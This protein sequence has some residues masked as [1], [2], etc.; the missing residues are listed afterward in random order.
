M[1]T[2]NNNANIPKNEFGRTS[3][4]GDDKESTFYYFH[5]SDIEKDLQKEH[6]K[7]LENCY[8]KGEEDGNRNLPTINDENITPFEH[9]LIAKYQSYIERVFTVGKQG[10]DEIHD[11]RVRPLEEKIASRGES[12]IKDE[13]DQAQIEKERKLKEADDNHDDRKKDIENS[14]DWRATRR[15]HEKVEKR[16]NEIAARVGREELH[17]QFRPFWAYILLILGIGIAE[18]PLNYQVFLEFRETPLLT[19]IMSF[20]LVITLPFLAHGSGKFLK[21][22]RENKTYFV[23]LAIAV[24]F[25]LAISYYTAELRTNYLSTKGISIE[26]LATDRWT[27]FLIGLILYFVGFIASYFAHDASMELSE[28]HDRYHRVKTEYDRTQKRIH[29]EIK[30]EKERHTTER[31]EAQNKFTQKKHEIS[32]R[33]E[34]WKKALHDARG[35]HDKM[36]NYSRGLERKIHQNCLEAIHHYRDTNLTFRTNHAQPKAWAHKLPDL[37]FRF[38][39]YP[40]LAEYEKKNI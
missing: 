10:L 20:V 35:E 13:T 6:A 1:T 27:F 7:C 15:E 19:L 14:P 37:S 33:I 29:D 18:I 39:D 22:G 34:N 31:E 25:I 11:Q 5:I 21:Q 2:K 36:L 12:L 17:I 4:N 32:S 30:N 23:L 26:R 24:F 38:S 3:S 16:F 28:I 40:E 8:K 9:S